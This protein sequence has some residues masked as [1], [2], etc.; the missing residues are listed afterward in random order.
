[1]DFWELHG[2]FFLIFITLFPRITM[3]V[4]GTVSSFGLLG[5]LGWIILP[6]FT[7]AILATTMYWDTNPVLCI[8]S[9]MFALGG[10][11]CETKTASCSVR[12]RA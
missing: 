9:W 1:M 8:L 5:W 3:L 2:W 4:V 12:R 11:L 7:V 6:H 10:T